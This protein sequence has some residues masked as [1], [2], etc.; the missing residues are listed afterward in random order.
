MEGEH[1]SEAGQL[2]QLEGRRSAGF[3]VALAWFPA[4]RLG[5]ETRLDAGQIAMSG[6]SGLYEVA[7]QYQARQPPDDA[8]R[9]YEYTRSIAWPSVET[10]LR[11]VVV[12]ANAAAR[13]NPE[14]RVHGTLSGGL[15]FGTIRGSLAPVGFTTFRLG[16]HAVLLSEQYGVE[17]AFGPT[18][19]VGVNAGGEAEI[20]VSGRTA[21]VVGGRLIAFRDGQMAAR[22]TNRIDFSEAPTTRS[23]QEIERLLQP[24]PLRLQPRIA[25]LSAGLRI[26]L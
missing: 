20:P 15:S 8:L 5:L 7:L 17:L 10:S 13:L 4:G 24:A 2:F 9:D 11:Q 23:A 12:S 26:G 25:V 14:G 18:T 21:L 19:R 3:W 6:Q 22:V 16:G 1:T